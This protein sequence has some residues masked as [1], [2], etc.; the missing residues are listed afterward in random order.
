[1]HKGFLR[2]QKPGRRQARPQTGHFRKFNP[3]VFLDVERFWRPGD[4]RRFQ[5]LK[6]QI[7][8]CDVLH[9]AAV[10]AISQMVA[11]AALRSIIWVMRIQ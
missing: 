2:E 6:P 11:G 3:P 8:R 9:A 7:R 4:F 10:S 1:M 5:T